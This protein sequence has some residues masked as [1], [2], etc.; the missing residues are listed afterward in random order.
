[1]PESRFVRPLS[2][3][4]VRFLC[5]FLGLLALP[6]PAADKPVVAVLYFG[7]DG[8]TPE[9]GV[10]RKG[11]A[12][13][14]ITDLSGFGTA[15]LVER[16]RLQA[17]MDE[18]DLGQT[19][20]FDAATVAK[21]GRLLGARYLV[22]G[23]YFDLLNSL[24]VD[25]KVIEV[26]TGFIVRSLGTRGTTEEFFA[27]E[28][29]LAKDINKVLE[30]IIGGA[31]APSPGPPGGSGAPQPSKLARRLTVKTALRYSRALDAKDRKDVETAKKELKAVL[32]EQPD[33]T[34]A[35]ADLASLMK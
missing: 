8:K 20:R 13:M 10:L 12:Q 24:R 32:E 7:Y 31:S 23:D 3:L 9:L 16:D 5:L 27:F 11:L 2:P 4:L 19:S 21:L 1:V 34:L 30:E 33:F 28:Q 25:A 26:E 35:S 17:I 14:L 15:K 6:A 18:L 29:Q 22:F